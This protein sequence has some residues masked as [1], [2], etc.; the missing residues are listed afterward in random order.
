[1][2]EIVNNKTNSI[3]VD[4]YDYMLRDTANLNLKLNKFNYKILLKGAR[5]IGNEICYPAK[6]EEEVW[7]LYESRYML[8]KDIYNHRTVHSVELLI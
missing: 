4:K 8:H 7:K 3:D 5:V 1:M 2:F 6:K